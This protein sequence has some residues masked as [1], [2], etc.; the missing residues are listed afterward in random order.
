MRRIFAAAV[1]LALA[2]CAANSQVSTVPAAAGTYKL[3]AVDGQAVPHVIR[4]GEEVVGGMLLLKTDGTFEVRTD[5]KAQ[6][7]A[8]QPLAFQRQQLGTY[9]TTEIGV[10]LKWQLAAETSGAFFGRTLRIYNNGI[11]YLYMK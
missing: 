2:G 6:M 1:L 4:T 8:T 3:I 7:T 5:M 9:T 11:E 10:Q